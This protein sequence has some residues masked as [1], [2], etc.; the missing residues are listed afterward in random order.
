M[1]S[2]YQRLKRRTT[3]KD[4]NRPDYLQA[5]V[6]EFQDTTD[7]Q[8]KEQVLANLANFGY[9]PINF[10]YLRDLHVIDLFVD[11][12]DTDEDING[13]IV[14]FGVGGLCNLA[15][16][17]KNR[18]SILAIPNSIELTIRCL[19]SANKETVLSA[20]TLIMQLVVP[21][22]RPRIISPALISCMEKFST[23][24]DARLR[25][26]ACVFLEDYCTLEERSSAAAKTDSQP[27][28]HI[29]LP[30]AK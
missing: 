29:P 9:D 19:S 26:I 17:A 4:L 21:A 23:A 27:L 12:M 8:A 13:S 20:M 16:D 3:S 22:S 2:T 24:E 11:C 1:F 5:L 15:A 10:Q 18:E 28:L 25:N 6:T 30:P 14:E 7:K